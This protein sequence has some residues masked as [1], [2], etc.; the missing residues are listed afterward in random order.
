MNNKEIKKYLNFLKFK[1]FYKPSYT[2]LAK[3]VEAKIQKFL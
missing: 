2:N 3:Y 1:K